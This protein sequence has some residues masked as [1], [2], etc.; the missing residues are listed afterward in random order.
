MTMAS[1][2]TKPTLTASAISDKLS[3]EKPAT[4]IAAQ[5]PESANGTV[6]PAAAVGA[7][8]RRKRNT[9]SITRTMVAASV[10][11]MSRTLARIVCVRSVNTEISRPAGTHCRSS[12]KS[13]LMRST[14]SMTLAS[15]C[16]VITRRTEGSRLYQP[17]ARLLRTLGRI[18]AMLD[19]RMTVPFA[20][21]T[22]NGSYSLALRSWSL[23]PMVTPRLSPSKA[24]IGPT[25]LEFEIAVRT[26]SI[27]SPMADK[28]AG[29]TR[30]RIAGCSDP[31][32]VTS[33]TPSTCDNRCAM[34]LSATS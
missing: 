3:M 34:M 24:P 11:C 15:P 29:S 23:M 27:D 13:S 25:A 33:A 21:F 5:V 9:T 2:T 14:V 6:T 8:R 17:A 20:V 18:V 30:T 28:R 31:A 16:L 4:H 12:G 10:S 26:S 7:A 22:T 19:R 1:S 32:T